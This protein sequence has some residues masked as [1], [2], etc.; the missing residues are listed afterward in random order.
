[1]SF[2]AG[3]SG[4]SGGHA[5][6]PVPAAG[7]ANIGLCNLISKATTFRI[8]GTQGSAIV[9]KEVPVPPFSMMWST[10]WTT[11]DTNMVVVVTPYFTKTF[12]PFVTTDLVVIYQQ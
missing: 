6:A 2:P 10:G 4:T 7:T 11:G 8:S 5:P 3:A 12:A 1:M 9:T